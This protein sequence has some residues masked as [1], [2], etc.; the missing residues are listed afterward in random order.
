[1]RKIVMAFGIILAVLAGA[2]V[3]AAASKPVPVRKV[4]AV[5][6][7]GYRIG[8]P[9]DLNMDGWGRGSTELLCLKVW[10]HDAYTVTYRDGSMTETPA[11]PTVVNELVHGAEF[12]P[13]S[14]RAA[15]IREGLLNEMREYGKR[16]K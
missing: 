4:T 16:D 6:A 14:E 11:G 9:C 15:Y 2:S 10:N 8:H 3:S 1:M 7:I 5:P 13:K 12:E